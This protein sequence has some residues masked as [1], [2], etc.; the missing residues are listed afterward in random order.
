MNETIFI[1]ENDLSDSKRN[2]IIALKRQHWP[3]DL[4]SQREWMRKNLNDSDVHV[5]LEKDGEL[6]AYLNL[7]KID[8]CF[9]EKKTAMTGIGNVCTH[10]LYLHQGLATELVLKVNEYLISEGMKGILLCHEQ[11]LSFY[12]KCGWN[13]ISNN[14]FEIYIGKQ[15]YKLCT[16]CYNYS[17]PKNTIAIIDRNF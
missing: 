2:E 15:K 12:I 4:E 8:V 16:M 7:A 14:L 1:L 11:L 3:Y 5:C 17:P 6:V 9:G 13:D 10:K